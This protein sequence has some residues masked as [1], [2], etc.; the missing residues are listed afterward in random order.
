M[1][2]QRSGMKR[3]VQSLLDMA[4][5]EFHTLFEDPMSTF[6]LELLRAYPSARALSR[7]KRPAVAKIVREHTRGKDVDEESSR[8]VEAAKVS[9]AAESDGSSFEPIA[10]QV[11]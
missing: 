3:H 5:P 8:L 7:A 11:W 9:L 10:E 1:V 4:F 2:E 6:A